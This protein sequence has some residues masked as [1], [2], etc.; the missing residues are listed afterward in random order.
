MSKSDEV[1][2]STLIVD[3]VEYKRK[4]EI[5]KAQRIAEIQSQIDALVKEREDLKG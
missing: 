5:Q 4:W 1:L 3:P 2:E